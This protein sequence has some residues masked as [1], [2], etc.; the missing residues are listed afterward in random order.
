MSE[1]LRVRKV[2]RVRNA[3]ASFGPE[4]FQEP[5]PANPEDLE[6]PS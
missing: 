3:T 5:D 4:N 6:D 2:L 1:V